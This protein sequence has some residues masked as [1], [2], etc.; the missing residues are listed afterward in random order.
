MM[1]FL[2]LLGWTKV[3]LQRK[4]FMIVERFD[5]CEVHWSQVPAMGCKRGSL[6][7]AVLKGKL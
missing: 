5:P 3:L 1:V 4:M 2:L 6:S 7:A